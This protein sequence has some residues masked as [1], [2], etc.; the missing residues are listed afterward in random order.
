MSIYRRPQAPDH[1]SNLG[2][3]MS[4]QSLDAFSMASK[5]NRR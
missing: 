3:S 5:R 4:T 1:S 2:D